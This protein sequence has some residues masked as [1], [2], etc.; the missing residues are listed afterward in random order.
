M[1][2]PFCVV[3]VT[4]PPG[5]KARRLAR[6]ILKSRCAACVNIIPRVHSSYWWKGK[7]E[8]APEALLI[9]KTRRS[10]INR[11]MRIV[12]HSHPYTVPEIIALPIVHGD[13]PYLNW[14]RNETRS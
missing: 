1:R 13:K 10:L 6:I 2:T 11:L 5:K 4:A 8:M 12:R 7:L 3:Y 9:I 14:V